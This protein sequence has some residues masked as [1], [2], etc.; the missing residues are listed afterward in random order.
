MRDAEDEWN[1]EVAETLA[2]K[3][4]VKEKFGY[5]RL[6][7]R[8]DESGNV[9]FEVIDPGGEVIAVVTVTPRKM[10]KIENWPI[11]LVRLD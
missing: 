5:A 3:A 11:D 6:D 2:T 10:G 7:M 4:L 8:G 9:V 1:W